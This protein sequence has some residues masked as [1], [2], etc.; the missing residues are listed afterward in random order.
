MSVGNHIHPLKTPLAAHSSS[1]AREEFL[2]GWCTDALFRGVEAFTHRGDTQYSLDDLKELAQRRGSSQTP[3][4]DVRHD[5]APARWFSKVLVDPQREGIPSPGQQLAI[6]FDRTI[7]PPARGQQQA[8]G[9]THNDAGSRGRLHSPIDMDGPPAE[10]NLPQTHNAEEERTTGHAGHNHDK[11][12]VHTLVELRP[13]SEGFDERSLLRPKTGS[14]RLD[15]TPR[16]RG[17]ASDS[18]DKVGRPSPPGH[19]SGQVTTPRTGLDHC[20]TPLA[21][22]N[23]PASAN[24]GRFDT[25]ADTA[26]ALRPLRDELDEFDAQLLQMSEVLGGALEDWGLGDGRVEAAMVRPGE[27]SEQPQLWTTRNTRTTPNRRG[28]GL[29]DSSHGQQGA[30]RMLHEDDWARGLQ[31]TEGGDGDD[32]DE[33]RHECHQGARSVVEMPMTMAP[34]PFTGFT[35]PHL[36]Y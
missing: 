15:T 6:S 34:E 11:F 31:S 7:P 17:R 18:D 35:R 28:H 30:I 9:Q 19:G 13:D 29:S 12:R 20:R 24:L 36:L 22:R 5:T 27:T 23:L 14:R 1:S 2:Q 3:G 26:D 25:T 33:D 21:W 16:L 4:A 32:D 8:E 10:P